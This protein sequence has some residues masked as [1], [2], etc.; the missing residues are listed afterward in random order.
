MRIGRRP[1]KDESVVVYFRFYHDNGCSGYD[2][3]CSGKLQEK[4]KKGEIKMLMALLTKVAVAE[5]IELFLSGA[6]AAITLL[7]T[8]SKVR[9]RR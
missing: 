1:S 6:S 7:C 4:R 9:K 5:A 2:R 8:G 3:Q